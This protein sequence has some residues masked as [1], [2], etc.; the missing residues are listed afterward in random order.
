[1]EF[2]SRA[3]EFFIY[4][5]MYNKITSLKFKSNCGVSGANFFRSEKKNAVK[6]REEEKSMDNYIM[7]REW[8]KK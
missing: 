6:R 2:C 5:I 3:N 8:D 1:M 4:T 7:E